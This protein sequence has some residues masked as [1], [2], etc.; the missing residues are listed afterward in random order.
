MGGG[1]GATRRGHGFQAG[2]AKDI[3]RDSSF[4]TALNEKV[5]I[6]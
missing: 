6:L 1:G 4:S 2:V 3:Y 5:H